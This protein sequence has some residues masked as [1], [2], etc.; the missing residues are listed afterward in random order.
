MKWYGSY[1]Y[2]KNKTFFN[3]NNK[4]QKKKKSL[5]LIL[6]KNIGCNFLKYNFYL[7]AKW[8]IT[9]INKKL[10]PQNLFCYIYCKTYFF[11]LCI[12]KKFLLFKYDKQTNLLRFHFF[13]INNFYKIFWFNFK[14]IFYSFSRLFFKKLKFKGKGY[15]IYKNQRNTVALQF[16]YSHLLYFYAFFI[17][18]KFLTKTSIILFGVNKFDINF[19]SYKL[20][21]FK[22]I[23]IFTGKG[24]RFSSQII[25]KKTGKVSSYR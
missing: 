15:Y 5:N 20:F 4:L 7:P 12:P 16:G 3:K 25:Y 9:L 11:L 21:K 8:S 6:S 22:P 10:N 1:N 2:L 19:K 14:L 24:I 17:M 23:N 13:F 18:V